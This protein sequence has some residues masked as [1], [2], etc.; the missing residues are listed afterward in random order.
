MMVAMMA[1][2][3]T[4]VA[5]KKDASSSG[6]S[7]NDNNKLK[8]ISF[9]EEDITLSVGETYSPELITDPSD[10]DLPK[11]TFTSDNKNVAT[12]NKTTGAITAVAKG[13]AVIT[14]K[15]S[16]GKFSAECLVTVIDGDVPPPPPPGECD[17]IATNVLFADEAGVASVKCVMGG[18]SAP[19]T[20]AT[21]QFS[22][23]GFKLTLP[24]TVD[25]KYLSSDW[26]VEGLVM[27]QLD[28]MALNAGGGEIGTCYKF[29]V[30]EGQGY[31]GGWYYYV[32]N[33]YKDNASGFVLKKGWNLM[34]WVYDMNNKP[35]G[36]TTE[37]F[38][39]TQWVFQAKGK[40]SSQNAIYQKL[41][42]N[43]EWKILK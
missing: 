8:G 25:D 26:G 32:K 27:G 41:L 16:N 28:I 43:K 10:A 38:T 5:C 12:V 36:V 24:A 17:V 22:N 42:N 14:A 37:E 21:A 40:S 19:I 20:L 35:L 3:M 29:G 6:S 7:G 34:F 23:K 13:E 33:E 31:W 9:E 2:S 1:I 18:N 39:G 15:T 4:F 11:C 30:A